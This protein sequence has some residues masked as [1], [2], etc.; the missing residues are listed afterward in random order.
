[1]T[2]IATPG[3]NSRIDGMLEIMSDAQTNAG[4]YAYS[5]IAC[6]RHQRYT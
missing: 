6:E 1:M 5:N 3:R 4:K 2:V